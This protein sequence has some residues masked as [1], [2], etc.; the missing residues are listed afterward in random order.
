MK[1]KCWESYCYRTFINMGT[2]SAKVVFWKFMVKDLPK[3]GRW[4]GKGVYT[5]V[6]LKIRFFL[7]SKILLLY[8]KNCDRCFS[9]SVRDKLVSKK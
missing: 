9:V 1:I 5:T 6:K 8:K 3:C 4:L 7:I 2:E